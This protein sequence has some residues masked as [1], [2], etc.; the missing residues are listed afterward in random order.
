MKTLHYILRIY[1]ARSVKKEA[2]ARYT[3]LPNA[4]LCMR[5]NVIKKYNTYLA[6]PLSNVDIYMSPY[7]KYD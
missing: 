2:T 4:N 6:I 3:H 5:T 1:S 7:V